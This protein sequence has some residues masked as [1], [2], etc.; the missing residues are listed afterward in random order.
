MTNERDNATEL[1]MKALKLFIVLI[2]IFWALPA[3]AQIESELLEKAKQGDAKAQYEVAKAYYLG[4]GV[5]HDYKLAMKWLQKAAEQWHAEAQLLLGAMY[6]DDEVGSIDYQKAVQLLTKAAHQA[7]KTSD[8][9]DDKLYEELKAKNELDKYDWSEIFGDK[10]VYRRAKYAL[11]LLHLNGLGVPQDY[12]IAEEMFIEAT[13]QGALRAE[14]E[15]A[16]IYLKGY[17]GVPQNTQKALDL[18]VRM[19]NDGIYDIP[20][21]LGKLY[22]DGEYVKQDMITGCAWIYISKDPELGVSCDGKLTQQQ[23]AESLRLKNEF[24][25]DINPKYFPFGID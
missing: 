15:L 10:R 4:E 1:P 16:K 11:G 12:K 21:F 2:S 19:T 13:N 7:S 23:L 3:F 8:K 14:F 22:L 24:E 9:W 18:L 20:I 17:E 6:C 25:K 5:P